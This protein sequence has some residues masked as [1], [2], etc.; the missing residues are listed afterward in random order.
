MREKKWNYQLP[1]QKYISYILVNNASLVNGKRDVRC[2]VDVEGREGAA[3]SPQKQD[4][5]AG[6]GARPAR[7]TAVT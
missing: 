2:Q 3:P 4:V 5:N 6:G 1:K 7:L